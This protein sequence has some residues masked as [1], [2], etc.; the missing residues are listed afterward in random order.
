M[1]QLGR[2]STIDRLRTEPEDCAPRLREHGFT[3]H[4]LTMKRKAVAILRG[5]LASIKQLR[6][7]DL[8]NPKIRG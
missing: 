5:R 1:D 4:S 7:D 6:K 2:V 8:K 3:D